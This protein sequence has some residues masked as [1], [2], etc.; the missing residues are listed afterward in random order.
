ME[1]HQVAMAAGCWLAAACTLAVQAAAPD[2]AGAKPA[3]PRNYRTQTYQVDVNR[4]A[5]AAWARV[6]RYCD[7]AAWG[8]HSCTL[9]SGVEEQ[10]GSVWLKGGNA[11]EILVAKTDLSYTYTLPVRA[12]VTHNFYHATLEARPLTASTSRLIWSVIY[13]AGAAA[14]E[15]TSAAEASRRDRINARLQRMKTL[16]EGGSL[17]AAAHTP[18]PRPAAPL[19]IPHPSYVSFALTVD[20]D[21]PAQAVWARFGKYCG[22]VIEVGIACELTSGVDGQLGA[23]R[24]MN[25]RLIEPLVART[26][27]SYTYIEP[28]EAGVPVPY[29]QYHATLEAR[30]LTEATSRL[31]YSVFYD[32]STLADDTA[33]ATSVANRRQRIGETL[34]KMKLLAEGGTLTPAQP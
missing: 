5:E 8:D 10:P 4:A 31:V 18:T 11:I 22:G 29:N 27:L 23:V 7:S 9:L 30:P 20:V 16:A 17:P 3:V 6:G 21:R 26:D 12:G 25:K 14:D 32:S 15:A 24:V 33:R 34:R 19:A 1:T 13:D 2:P 28:G